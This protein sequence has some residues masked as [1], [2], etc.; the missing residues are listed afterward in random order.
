MLD[1]ETLA[2]SPDAAV[3][4]IG[5]AFFSLEAEGDGICGQHVCV[6]DLNEQLGRLKRYVSGSTV[7]WWMQQD[8]AARSVFSQPE[9]HA[10]VALQAFNQWLPPD[11]HLWGNGADFDLPIILSLYEQ[12][13][14]TPLWKFYNHRCFRTLKNLHPK[15]YDE[16][17]RKFSNPLKHNA[18]ADATWQAQVAV[19]ILRKVS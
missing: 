4:S 13:V 7:R 9:T 14:L 16:A 8:Q 15:L 18:L 10:A 1:L 17:A 19:H 12:L 2:T 11:P 5:A 3:V 6:L